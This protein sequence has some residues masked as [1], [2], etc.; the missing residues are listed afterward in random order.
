MVKK[1]LVVLALALVPVAAHA[2][3][4]VTSAGP[5]AGLSMDP[6]QL[7]VGGQFSM[8]DFAPNWSF[9]PNIELGFGD[10]IQTIQLDL[11][12]YYRFRLQG[13]EWR[14]YVGGGLGIAFYSW[15]A[16]PGYRDDS[17]TETG[18]NVVGGFVVPTRSPHE[19]FVELR[20]G[21]GDIPELKVVTGMNFRI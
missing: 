7:V 17:E 4:M 12:A 3:A 15:D 2:Q 9:D 11:D 5:R 20:L 13:T 6:D 8:R 19:W 1:L 16:P 10:D 18:I 14:P 21:V